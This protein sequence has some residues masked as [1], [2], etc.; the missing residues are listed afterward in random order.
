MNI[1]GEMEESRQ[2]KEEDERE[3]KKER[4]RKFYPPPRD[5]AEIRARAVRPCDAVYYAFAQGGACT[6]VCIYA[7][8]PSAIS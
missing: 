3:K 8:I 4:G 5:S 7:R 2:E 6:Y 1:T